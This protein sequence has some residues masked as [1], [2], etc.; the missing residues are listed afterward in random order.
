[1]DWHLTSF[2]H[3]KILQLSKTSIVLLLSVPLMFDIDF[4]FVA[5][6]SLPFLQLQPDWEIIFDRLCAR[7]GEIL[8]NFDS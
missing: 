6:E 4:T 7:H 3:G 8:T 2:R 5:L 1:M